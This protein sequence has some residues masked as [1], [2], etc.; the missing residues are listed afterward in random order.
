[1]CRVELNQR[2]QCS[3]SIGGSHVAGSVGNIIML[4]SVTGNESV[5]T[6]QADLQ[7]VAL[8]RQQLSNDSA[9]S[10]QQ[11]GTCSWEPA[12]K[13]GAAGSSDDATE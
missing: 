12:I 9:V 2:V 13:I 10:V 6:Q 1:M 8:V 7:F 5:D 11:D 4:S 3:N